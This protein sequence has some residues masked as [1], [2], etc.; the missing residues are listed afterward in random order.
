MTHDNNLGTM[1][2][3]GD[4][5]WA[6]FQAL[7]ATNFSSNR[8]GIFHY[9]IFA[10]DLGS[11]LGSVSGISR[12][13]WPDTTFIKGA[14]DFIVSMGSWP[15][16][17]TQDQREGT[18]THEL[19]HNLGLRHGGS[20][21]ANYKPNYLSIMNYFY[22]VI[23]VYRS[24]GWGNFDYSRFTA[25]TLVETALNENT[26]LGATAAGYGARWY[27]PNTSTNATTSN[28]HIDWNCDGDGGVDA[29]VSVDI[30]YSG[31]R[32]TLTSQNNWANVVFGGNGV[33]GAGVTNPLLDASSI[34]SSRVNC[35]TFEDARRADRAAIYTPK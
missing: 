24:G 21:H 16:M 35:L 20:D 14:T 18:F 13:G 30:N 33:I 34:T 15:S 6:E 5:D 9:M 22:Q 8:Y 10:H 19:G 7:K 11:A 1:T 26:G 28:T 31:A 12:N 3:T 29:S 2:G 27:C 23:G 25:A 4:Y 17:G 32:T